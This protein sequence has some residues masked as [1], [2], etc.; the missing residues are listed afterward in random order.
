MG[1]MA[2]INPD[3]AAQ[4][5]SD[6]VEFNPEAAGQIAAG[7]SQVMG[8]QAAQMFNANM[9]E[10]MGD[11]FADMQTHMED[12]MGDMA[13]MMGDMMAAGDFMNPGMGARETLGPQGMMGGQM[14]MLG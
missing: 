3:M 13:Q 8:A 6:M 7:M 12:M 9:G 14:D 2:Q 5:A 4:F 11:A 10:I 1:Q